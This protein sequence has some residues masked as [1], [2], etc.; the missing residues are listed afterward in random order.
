MEAHCVNWHLASQVQIFSS[1]CVN[2]WGPRIYTHV[3]SYMY[4]CILVCVCTS[5]CVC[6]CV[7]GEVTGR[8][9]VDVRGGRAFDGAFVCMIYIQGTR[10][11]PATHFQKFWAVCVRNDKT[12]L[13]D[14]ELTLDVVFGLSSSA[15][16][17]ECWLLNHPLLRK[18]PLPFSLVLPRTH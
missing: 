4:S 14:V 16:S 17:T 2:A 3:C 13:S 7:C 18:T 9:F 5:V 8:V 12:N 6:V 10:N 1:K 15:S 11:S